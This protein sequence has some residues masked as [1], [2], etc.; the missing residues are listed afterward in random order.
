MRLSIAVAVI[1]IAGGIT[2]ELWPKSEQNLQPT[3]NQPEMG[4][5]MAEVILAGTL[6][7]NSQVGKKSS[8]RQN[9][10]T[11]APDEQI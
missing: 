4:E 11:S 2:F 9:C 1:L 6:S 5:V 10:L 8:L 7:Q 3:S